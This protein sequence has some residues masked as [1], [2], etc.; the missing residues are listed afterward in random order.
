MGVYWDTFS[1][2][3]M[4]YFYSRI[5]IKLAL[6]PFSKVETLFHIVKFSFE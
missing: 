2:Q 4:F 6:N 1:Y 5:D 3:G